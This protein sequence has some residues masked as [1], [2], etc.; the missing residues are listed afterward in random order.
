MF[1]E[2]IATV[3]AGVGAA[4]LALALNWISGGRLPRWTMPVAAGIGMIAMTVWSE[5]NWY[6]RTVAG[7]PEGLE[8]AQVNEARQF[9][10]PWTYAAPMVDRFMAV[11][12]A[13]MQ[14][15]PDQPGQH[16][17][18]IYLMGRWQ[19]VRSFPVAIDCDGHR[20]AALV[21]DAGFDASGAVEGAQWTDVPA[22][23]PL[24]AATCARG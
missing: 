2:L 20:R 13:R 19:P 15:N 7:M 5:Y 23:D 8:V 10:R 14:S 24:L 22:S 16:I 21:E 4:G 17:A 12:V 6:D 1:F 9:Y 18:N 11:D 3:F